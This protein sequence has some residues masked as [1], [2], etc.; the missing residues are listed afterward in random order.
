MTPT[1]PFPALTRSVSFDMYEKSCV[2]EVMLRSDG[3]TAGD[4]VAVLLPP[5]QAAATSP[6]NAIAGSSFGNLIWFSLLSK[7]CRLLPGSPGARVR[8]QTVPYSAALAD[9]GLTTRR[10]TPPRQ[11]IARPLSFV[12]S[13]L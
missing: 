7:S 11:S 1:D 3:P 5:P 2:N 8:R 4:V 6:T 13:R 10:G 9:A 12:K